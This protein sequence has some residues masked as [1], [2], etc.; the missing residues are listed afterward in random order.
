VRPSRQTGGHVLSSQ[1]TIRF[2]DDPFRHPSAWAA[3]IGTGLEQTARALQI[4]SG[5]R[6]IE[7]LVLCLPGAGRGSSDEPASRYLSQTAIM[8]F[9]NAATLG[10]PRAAAAALR[11]PNRRAS[12]ETL[13]PWQ[14]EN[15]GVPA[16]L[17]AGWMK[18]PKAM[19]SSPTDI[20]EPVTVLV[21]VAITD[22]LFAPL[23]AT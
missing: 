9:C 5:Q 19:G 16:N 15:P 6:W 4:Q 3:R 14:F 2:D 13:T 8:A 22:T 1:T 12:A 17:G 7:F 20:G 18:T 23:F 10:N 11:P 21:A